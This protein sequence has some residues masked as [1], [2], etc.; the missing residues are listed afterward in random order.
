ME[1]G[2][3]VGH[4]LILWYAMLSQHKLVDFHDPVT[5]LHLFLVSLLLLLFF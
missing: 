2:D 3:R 5:L 4:T 1:D